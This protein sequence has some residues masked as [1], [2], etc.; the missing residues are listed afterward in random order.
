MSRWVGLLKSSQLSRKQTTRNT[1]TV[2]RRPVLCAGPAVVPDPKGTS[3]LFSSC[4]IRARRLF[5]PPLFRSRSCPEHEVFCLPR[6][7][8]W[9]CLESSHTRN[10][11][12]PGLFF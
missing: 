10:L 3:V 9:T 6:I 12:M 11:I 8:F 4:V 1:D 2:L 7:D 5:S